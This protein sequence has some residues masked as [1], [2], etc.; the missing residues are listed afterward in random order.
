MFNLP[1]RSRFEALTLK[2]YVKVMSYIGEYVIEWHFITYKMVKKIQD[3]SH[4]VIVSSAVDAYECP[5]V[6]VCVCVRACVCVC[7]CVCVH[8]LVNSYWP[9]YIMQPATY[10]KISQGH[11]TVTRNNYAYVFFTYYLCNDFV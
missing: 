4:T 5:C 1:K 10:S 8:P 3:L 6:C 7:S 2:K 9:I 11:F